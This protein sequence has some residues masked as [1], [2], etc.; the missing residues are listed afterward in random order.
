MPLLAIARQRNDMHIVLHGAGLWVGHRRPH[1]GT[2][3]KAQLLFVDQQISVATGQ[4]FGDRYLNRLLLDSHKYL[5]SRTAT[6]RA[7]LALDA[8]GE[9]RWPCYRRCSTPFSSTGNGWPIRRCYVIWRQS[10]RSTAPRSEHAMVRP[11]LSAS[12]TDSALVAPSA[13]PRFSCHG[14]GNR[15]ATASPSICVRSMVTGVVFQEHL[16]GPMASPMHHKLES[17]LNN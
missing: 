5:D 6:A 8:L 1:F 2:S 17:G 4:C 7:L 16:D 3:L 11:S 14:V 10:S 9:M 15:R 13:G 12:A